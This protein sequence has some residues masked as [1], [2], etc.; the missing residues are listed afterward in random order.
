MCGLL[1]MVSIDRWNLVQEVNL[2]TLLKDLGSLFGL[3]LG[4]L[5]I[6]QKIDRGKIELLKVSGDA[7]IRHE[8]E[9]I[10]GEPYEEGDGTITADI[11]VMKDGDITTLTLNFKL[12]NTHH[13]HT[14]GIKQIILRLDTKN[15]EN[16]TR[17]ELIQT[18]FCEVGPRKTVDT[19]VEFR[20]EGKLEIA[21][22]L[23]LM[24]TDYDD[25]KYSKTLTE[26]EISLMNLTDFSHPTTVS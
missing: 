16:V 4:I 19:S 1:S 9:P 22:G 10:Y 17:C 11:V 5:T 23:D 25:K 13:T 3:I 12:I 21:P 15:K 24:L 6:I 7:T 26:K 2:S 20:F 8:I 18:R 14:N